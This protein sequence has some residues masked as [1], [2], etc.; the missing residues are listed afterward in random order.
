MIDLNT[1][2]YENNSIS[3]EP[4]FYRGELNEVN[5]VRFPRRSGAGY[6]TFKIKLYT[7][8]KRTH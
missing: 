2:T 1:N 4:R 5:H 8:E 6:L 3:T 7:D